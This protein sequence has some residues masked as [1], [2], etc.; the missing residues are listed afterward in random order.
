MKNT[1]YLLLLMIGLPVAAQSDNVNGT[2]TD[3]EG[4]GLP[5]VTIV[6]KHTKTGTVSDVEG[7]FSLDGVS[8]GDTLVF[9]YV[10]FVTEEVPCGDRTESMDISLVEDV[11]AL[12]EVVF[13]GY[14]VVKKHCVTAAISTVRG[15]STKRSRRSD[16]IYGYSAGD[17]GSQSGIRS[18]LLTAG[19]VNDFAKWE[20][21][22]DI[23]TQEL[24]RYQDDWEIKPQDRYT[25]Q[26]VDEHKFPVINA[27]VNLFDS[28]GTVMWVARTDNTG[29]AELWVEKPET[30]TIAGNYSALI[31]YA[32]NTYHIAQ[33]KEFHEGVNFLTLPVTADLSDG[34]EIAFVVDATGSMGDEIAYLKTELRDV[35]AR[36]QDSLPGINLS[37]GS[38]FY[39]DH[40][41]EYVTRYSPLS[42]KTQKAVD[43]VKANDAGGGGDGPEAVEEA[44]ETTIKKLGW[45]DEAR[46]RIVFLVLDAPPHR[47]EKDIVKV[48]RMTEQAAAMGIRIVPVTCSGIDK[49]TEYLMRNIALITNGTYTFLTDDSGIGNPH[50]KPSTDDYDVELLNDL[51]IRLV[52]QY[53]HVPVPEVETTA[54]YSADTLFVYQ[55]DTIPADSLEEK[56]S[57]KITLFGPKEEKTEPAKKL[58]WK[59]YPNPTTGP[60]SVEMELSSGALYITDLAGKILTKKDITEVEEIRLDLSPYPNGLYLLTYV[61]GPDKQIT[62][63]VVLRR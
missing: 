21:W 18:G 49:S 57:S 7:R 41:D 63:Q 46:T 9:S 34:V 1:L 19:E 33:L 59:Y 53:T 51:L 50:I 14:G 26:L 48:K 15:K 56:K 10:G 23:S 61:Y 45:S 24:G 3:S 22:Q 17:D 30:D 42:T 47:I 5:G 12:D 54:E 8:P 62:G 11:V 25:V 40:G 52:Y 60:L 44:L 2:I 29:K 20:L 37:L 6:I 4:N 38:V 35:M 16:K 55:P 32:G 13:V 43:F 31:S 27:K 36:I 39:R 28:T 58:A